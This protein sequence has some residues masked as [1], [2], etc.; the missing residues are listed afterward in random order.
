M[1]RVEQTYTD[2]QS[3]R[4]QG[5]KPQTVQAYGKVKQR[6]YL[7]DCETV[8]KLFCGNPAQALATAVVVVSLRANYHG[9]GL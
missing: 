8:L 9:A 4:E 2:L 5:A 7:F 6:I 1:W 3:R